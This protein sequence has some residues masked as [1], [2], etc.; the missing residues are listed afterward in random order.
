MRMGDE[1]EALLSVS[2]QFHLHLINEL[3]IIPPCSKKNLRHF[4]P[5]PF[6]TLIFS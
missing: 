5:Q 6:E 1:I 3:L 2:L 4:L